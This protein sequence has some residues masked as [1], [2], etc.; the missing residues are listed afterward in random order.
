M[1]ISLVFAYGEAK[2]LLWLDLIIA[3]CL[4]CIITNCKLHVCLHQKLMLNL[5]ADSHCQVAHRSQGAPL[6]TRV[7][8]ALANPPRSSFHT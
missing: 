1:L 8:R 4:N 5:L 2:H 6:S 3:D 7:A